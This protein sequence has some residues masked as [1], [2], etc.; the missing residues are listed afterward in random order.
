M[1]QLVPGLFVRL[2]CMLACAFALL[3]LAGCGG[4]GGGTSQ[5]PNPVSQAASSSS[6][7]SSSSESSL[8][9]SLSSSSIASSSSSSS[10]SSNAETVILSGTITYDFI[11]HNL[12]HIGLNYSGVEQRPVRGVVVDLLDEAGQVKT[13]TNSNSVGSY[14]FSVQKNTLVKVRVKAQLLSTASPSWNFKV[15]D[16]TSN[17]A[18]YVLDGAL[19]SS[20][21]QN[22]KRNLNA[23]SGWDGMTYSATRAAAPFAILDNIYI[24]LGRITAAGNTKNLRSLELRWSTK[25][26]AADGDA[27]RGEI[28]TSYYDGNAIYVLGDANHDIDEYDSHVLLHEWGHYIEEQLFRSDSIGGDHSDGDLLDFRVAMS[29]GF[30]NA[31][32]G[33][34]IDNVN[35]ADASGNAQTSGFTFSIARKNR[36]N[37]G[38]FNEGSV[39]SILF[40]YYTNGTSKSAN[41]FTPIFNAL[42]NSG[43]VE[44]EAFTSIF[45]FFSQFKKQYP[46][47]TNFMGGLLQEQQIFGVDEFAIDESNSGGLAITLPLYKPIAA[48]NVAV[49]VCS[50]SNYGKQNKLGNSQFLKLNITQ[51]GVYNIRINKSGGAEVVSKPEFLVYQKGQLLSYVAN[52]LVDTASGN[53][54]LSRGI[55]I[56][57]VYDFNNYDSDNDD[58]NMTCFN[59]RVAAN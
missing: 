33:M 42:S 8:V 31:F 10:L 51:A 18:L 13:S 4:G 40:N 2:K 36:I 12:N 52:T 57:E 43:Y 5:P 54:S 23:G 15:T 58:E 14:S 48:N 19:V 38:Y 11:P 39:G 9:I 47:Q 7:V 37:K 30:A 6:P 16:N 53:L 21:S 45:L 35:Y 44:S 41:D 32:S 56:V 17:N 26:S 22:S 50:A 28:G 1:Q 55:F 25:N 3:I 24:A 59:V 49:N 20:G 34:M 46:A 29:E 27:S